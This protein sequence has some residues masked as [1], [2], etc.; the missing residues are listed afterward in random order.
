MIM[1][2]QVEV[3]EEDLLVLL[4]VEPRLELKNKFIG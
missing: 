1:K 4:D 2:I 3:D